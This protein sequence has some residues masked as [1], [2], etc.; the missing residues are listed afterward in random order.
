MSIMASVID[1]DPDTDGGFLMK[2]GPVTDIPNPAV[3]SRS[4]LVLVSN[5]KLTSEVAL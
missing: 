2:S 1:D 4:P 3:T 5:D